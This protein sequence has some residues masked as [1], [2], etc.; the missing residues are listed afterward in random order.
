[1]NKRTT[2]ADL[3]LSCGLI[4]TFC[5]PAPCFRVSS[6][7]A[8]EHRDEPATT[9]RPLLTRSSMT[10]TSRSGIVEYDVEEE[11]R[12]L[13]ATKIPLLNRRLRR[14][15]PAGTCHCRPPG[16]EVP[17]PWMTTLPP[18]R[19]TDLGVTPRSRGKGPHSSYR[20]TWT[21]DGQSLLV[22]GGDLQGREG[23][24]WCQG[25]VENMTK[26]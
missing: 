14:S 18:G 13:F 26:S 23:V 15:E 4:P 1:M 19:V 7:G 3:V 11:I 17:H 16:L 9:K 5:L 20:L 10:N 22:F 8:A 2:A 25:H 6:A 24:Y 21:P 12:L